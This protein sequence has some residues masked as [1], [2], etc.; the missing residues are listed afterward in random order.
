MPCSA[1]QTDDALT[2][3]RRERVGFV[4]QFFNLLPT[5]TAARERPLPLLL[6]RR[7]RP[8]WPNR[9]RERCSIASGSVLAPRTIRQ[10]L[11]GGELQR[12]GIGP[13]AHPPP[14]LLVADEPTGNLDSDNGARVS[15]C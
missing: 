10:Q 13:G 12:G 15:R 2:R 14:A 1:A 7:Q 5:L 11:S 6:A 9:P 8:P 3:I 4:F